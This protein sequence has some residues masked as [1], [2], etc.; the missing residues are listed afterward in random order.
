MKSI[1]LQLFCIL[2]LLSCSKQSVDTDNFNI[3]IKDDIHRIDLMKGEYEVFREDR[4]QKAIFKLSKR[5][6]QT[7]VNYLNRNIFLLEE[8][9]KDFYSLHWGLP[10][11]ETTITIF[12]NKSVSIISYCDPCY[13]PFNF[14][15]VKKA[16]E[17]VIMIENLCLK[18]DNVKKLLPSDFY[19]E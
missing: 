13:Y 7:I 3:L 14:I 16:N 8:G 15:R 2:T 12:N 9:K 17:L 19:L 6:R 10:V 5:D 18:N 1:L 4:N 11:S